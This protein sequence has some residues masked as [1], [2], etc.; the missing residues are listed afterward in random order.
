[1]LHE[2]GEWFHMCGWP[3][4]SFCWLSPF[5]VSLGTSQTAGRA[6]E[7][8]GLYSQEQKGKSGAVRTS[9]HPSVPQGCVQA[10]GR[11]TAVLMGVPCFTLSQLN[12]G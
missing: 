7:T 12:E 1:M 11:A 4:S 3:C 10:K 2:T 6:M 8:M 5:G 9:P